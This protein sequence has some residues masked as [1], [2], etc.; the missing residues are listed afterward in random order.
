MNL[1]LRRAHNPTPQPVSLQDSKARKLREPNLQASQRLSC[2]VPRVLEFRSEESEDF[3]LRASLGPTPW[4]Q[5]SFHVTPLVESRRR[6]SILFRRPACCGLSLFITQQESPRG[7][8][9]NPRLLYLAEIDSRSKKHLRVLGRPGSSPK[10]G[11]IYSLDASL[12]FAVSLSPQC[13]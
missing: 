8:F 5:C 11:S 7:Y 4:Q 13:P 9:R 2:H 3:P 10:K 6:H 12:R 1:G